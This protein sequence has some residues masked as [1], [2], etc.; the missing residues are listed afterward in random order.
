[1][2]K[3]FTWPLGVFARQQLTLKGTSKENWAELA[4]AAHLSGD[5]A[6][7][8]EFALKAGD[9][10][11]LHA[12]ER[13]AVEAGDLFDYQS[14][15]RTRGLETEAEKLKLIAAAAK[16]SSH[17]TFSQKAQVMLPAA[18]EAAPAG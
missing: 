6:D 3:K 16:A 1:M 15:R 11:L 12:L 18:D 2:A 9:D 4:R 8:A 13:E 5:I 17:E 14:V 10:K 7:A